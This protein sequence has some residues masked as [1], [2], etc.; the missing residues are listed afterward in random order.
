MKNVNKDFDPGDLIKYSVLSRLFGMD[1]SS[2][3]KN[4]MPNWCKGDVGK[5]K[6]AISEWYSETFD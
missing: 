4:R 6:L 3:S 2:V 1:R 5:L